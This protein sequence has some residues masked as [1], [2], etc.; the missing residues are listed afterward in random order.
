MD[1]KCCCAPAKPTYDELE[2]R[3]K[4]LEEELDYKESLIKAL[5]DALIR[6]HVTSDHY[7]RCSKDYEKYWKFERERANDLH[8]LLDKLD[9]K[10]GNEQS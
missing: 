6:E 2:C 4:D 7:K 5:Q 9:K 8:D 1:N 10:D 3:C